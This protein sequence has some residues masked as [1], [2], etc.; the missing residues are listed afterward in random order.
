[1]LAKT[2][3]AAERYSYGNGTEEDGEN[4]QRRQ[5]NGKERD[6]I[7]ASLGDGSNVF[8]RLDIGEYAIDYFLIEVVWKLAKA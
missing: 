5:Y 1:M 2:R 4:Q 3:L 6:W 8:V 7:A